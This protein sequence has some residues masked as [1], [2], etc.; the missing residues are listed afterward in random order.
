MSTRIG[1]GC[2]IG[3][4]LG[5]TVVLA[6]TLVI[7]IPLPVL[8]VH[9][10]PFAKVEAV[11]PAAVFA[12]LDLLPRDDVDAHNVLPTGKVG[13]ALVAQH[14]ALREG[15]REREKASK[16]ETQNA[17]IPQCQQQ[18]QFTVWKARS[19]L[20]FKLAVDTLVGQ[21]IINNKCCRRQ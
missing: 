2:S 13:V 20:E 10:R 11:A 7:C 3:I 16:Q 18:N 1:I 17:R 19:Q 14:V 12:T 4:V 15:G 9:E 21:D 5:L 8:E 6:L